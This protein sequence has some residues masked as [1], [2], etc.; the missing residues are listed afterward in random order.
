MVVC[1]WKIQREAL[2]SL[3]PQRG[4]SSM[5]Y[6]N[7]GDDLPHQGQSS[8][9]EVSQERDNQGYMSTAD[10]MKL[11]SD[12]QTRST[13][14]MMT[15]LNQMTVNNSQQLAIQQSNEDRKKEVHDQKSVIA[16]R[17][18]SMAKYLQPPSF[19]TFTDDN[20]SVVSISVS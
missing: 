9:P 5:Y 20:L 15:M 11:M 13:E 6:N 16:N 10:V 1:Q 2:M 4:S 17:I 3:S 7:S 14:M 18:S 19:K 12:Q 8:T